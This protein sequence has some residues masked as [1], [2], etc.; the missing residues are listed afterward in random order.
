MHLIL[1]EKVLV[2]PA[3]LSLLLNDCPHENAP[4]KICYNLGLNT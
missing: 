3:P 2:E 1:V 4:N